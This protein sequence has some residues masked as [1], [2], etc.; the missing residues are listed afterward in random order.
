VFL[1][2]KKNKTSAT[3]LSQLHCDLHSHLVWNIDDGVKTKEE[4]LA[5]IELLHTLG[6]KKIITTPHIHHDIYPN[7]ISV[8]TEGGEK[9]KK[10]LVA[11]NIEIEID[12]AAEYYFDQWFFNEVN[13][14]KQ[15]L[16]FGK[17]YLLFE[18]NYITEPYQ[19]K[20][21]IFTLITAGL[22]P[23]LAHPERY[24][25]MSVEKAEDLRT[26]GVLLQLNLLSLIG[27]YGKPV[28]AMAHKLIDQNLIDMVG[29]D[30]HNA[31]QAK[32]LSEVFATKYYKKVVNAP[33]L[34]HQL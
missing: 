10:E 31:E 14:G 2:G 17:K 16:T 11:A 3:V 28:Q 13:A 5:T 25:Y 6:Y 1:F 23:I 32:M 12:F 9:L 33:L 19:L 29:S 34:N 30:C 22:Q 4:S 20:S 21:L 7:E 18:T 8:I 24:Q 27:Y 15:L 26:R